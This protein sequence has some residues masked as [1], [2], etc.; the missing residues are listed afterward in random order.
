MRT[1]VIRPTH[2]LLPALLVIRLDW[3]GIGDVSIQGGNVGILI[4]ATCRRINTG[5]DVS[6]QALVV[7]TILLVEGA[8]RDPEPLTSTCDGDTLNLPS[9]L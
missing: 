1:Q 9:S 8:V 7:H 3:L 5:A 4:F 6:T 2:L